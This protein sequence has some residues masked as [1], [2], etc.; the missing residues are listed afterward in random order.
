MSSDQITLL[1]ANSQIDEITA[2]KLGIESHINNCRV[3]T[4]DNG[5]HAIQ[6][7][8]DRKFGISIADMRLTDMSG[9]KLLLRLKAASPG[10]T[11][12][13]VSDCN[14]DA[15][16]QMCLNSGIDFHF[17]KPF[18][19]MQLAKTLGTNIQASSSMFR[20]T[21]DD[22]N[23]PD[24][25]QL[26][27]DRPIPMLMRIDGPSGQGAIEIA[28][29]QVIHARMN[30]HIGE[31]AFFELVGWNEGHF[32]V[33][34]VVCPEERTIALPLQQLLM[35]AAMFHSE[36][37]Q[38]NETQEDKT[39]QSDNEPF[40]LP[41]AM[42]P[43]VNAVWQNMSHYKT[44]QPGWNRPKVT[45]NSGIDVG[46]MAMR[47]RHGVQK[48]LEQPLQFKK[49]P[50]SVDAVPNVKELMS[51]PTRPQQ[52]KRRSPFELPSARRMMVASLAACFVVFGSVRYLGLFS[53]NYGRNMETSVDHLVQEIAPEGNSFVEQIANAFD[54]Q[55]KRP[56]KA[57]VITEEDISR[58]MQNQTMSSPKAASPSTQLW[59]SYMLSVRN[60]DSLLG[61]ANLIGVAAH[62][63]DELALQENPWVELQGEAG[64]RI[65]GMALRMEGESGNIVLPRSLARALL[66]SQET[67]TEVRMRQVAWTSAGP[68]E[69]VTFERSKDLP[70]QYCEYWFAV[71]VSLPTLKKSG[72][73]PGEYASIRGP[74]GIQAVR[75]QLVDRGNK[76]VIWVSKPVRD[77][78][79]LANGT[80][81]VKL[82]PSS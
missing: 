9:L 35:K 31:Q 30:G 81:G 18:D 2:W 64:N 3:V 16:N 48:T 59:Q 52:T 53:S 21:L 5:S 45:G 72:L 71:G 11:T 29:G 46:P 8:A 34:D 39:E 74:N 32:E 50:H 6:L 27:I 38:M 14:N 13:L 51:K 44:Q 69:S 47:P 40:F 43:T 79:G 80:A 70:G 55:K 82:F 75:V 68:K 62:L 15:A 42:A 65:G 56:Q 10:I 19:L 36:Q 78:V 33:I 77:A 76:D 17:Q 60:D 1:L 66:L 63:Y 54:H 4:T 41:D 37:E 12:I 20:G 61:G 22:L 26:V 23:V 49:D 58:H 57:V 24:V 73:A 7:A 25:L 28:D 67:S